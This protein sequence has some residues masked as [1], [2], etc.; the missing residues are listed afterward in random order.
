MMSNYNITNLTKEEYDS[1]NWLL[2]ELRYE[3]NERKREVKKNLETNIMTLINDIE[4]QTTLKPEDVIEV[5]NEVSTN[6]VL[7]TIDI[8][9]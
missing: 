5:L 8:N 4:V 7:N 1:L 6:I 9:K 2:G 3:K